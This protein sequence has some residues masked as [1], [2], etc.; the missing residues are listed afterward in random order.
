MNN[1]LYVLCTLL[2]GLHRAVLPR[3]LKRVENSIGYKSSIYVYMSLVFY[4]TFEILRIINCK[5]R[6]KEYRVY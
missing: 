5:L 4:E 6:L 1:I 2:I 3:G